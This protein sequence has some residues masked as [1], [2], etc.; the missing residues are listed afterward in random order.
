MLKST[1]CQ[2]N[3]PLFA[4]FSFIFSQI[5][6]VVPP[7][8]IIFPWFFLESLNKTNNLCS[9]SFHACVFFTFKLGTPISSLKSLGLG[10]PDSPIV[11]RMFGFLFSVK[12]PA[13]IVPVSAWKGDYPRLYFYTM[14]WFL[15]L[16]IFLFWNVEIR[17]GY[18]SNNINI[19][20]TLLPGNLCELKKIFHKRLH[21][22]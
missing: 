5:I 12:N 9:L 1:H 21:S 2:K 11:E 18:S 14:G 19:P 10:I 22:K 8:N 16:R 20:P 7:R 4:K 6:S 3:S 15:N 13:S 17:K